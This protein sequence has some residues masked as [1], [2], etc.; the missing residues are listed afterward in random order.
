MFD[1][2][3][4]TAPEAALGATPA[5]KPYDKRYDGLGG[6]LILIG[7]GTALSPF[8]MLR[9]LITASRSAFSNGTWEAVTTAGSAAYHPFWG[10]FLI[11]EIAYTAI[12]FL[13]TVYMAFLFFG[14]K[15]AYPTWFI[16]FHLVT[17]VFMIV[18]AVLL[19]VVRPD[20]PLIDGT[21]MGEIA[22]AL[23]GC[24]V[25][26]PY[27]LISTRVESTFRR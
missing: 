21:G 6:W 13:V 27:M 18:D 2:N 7:I 4:Y 25:W 19:Q 17:L 12:C 23:F 3:P 5:E 14:K 10:P 20:L 11:L 24:F 16:W 22:R 1:S 9:Q 8:Q 26:I 15:R